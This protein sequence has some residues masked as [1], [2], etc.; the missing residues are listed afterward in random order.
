MKT[1]SLPTH[2]HHLTFHLIDLIAGLLHPCSTYPWT[3]K[4]MEIMNVLNPQYMG[5]ITPQNEGTL[6]SHG[7]RFVKLLGMVEL[8][9]C[10]CWGLYRG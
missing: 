6:G 9:C 10:F 2:I 3:P 1:K 8:Q 5:E 4:P 7:S